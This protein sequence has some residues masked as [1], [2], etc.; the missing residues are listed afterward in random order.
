MNPNHT[1]L[2]PTFSPTKI[3]IKALVTFYSKCSI[4]FDAEQLLRQTI[5]LI[6]LET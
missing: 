1:I 6:E 2:F 3:L 5:L 4:D